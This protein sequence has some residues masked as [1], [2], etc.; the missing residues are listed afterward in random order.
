MHSLFWL[1]HF[2]IEMKW[3]QCRPRLYEL[4]NNSSAPRAGLTHGL[5]GL[6]PWAPDFIGPPLLTLDFFIHGAAGK[7][8]QSYEST[9]TFCINAVSFSSDLC[10]RY[11]T[12]FLHQ[13]TDGT[14]LKMRS[15]QDVLL[16][17]ACQT[18]AGVPNPMQLLE[19]EQYLLIF[20]K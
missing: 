1:I 3:K 12:F 20:K 2:K 7:K 9:C 16:S 15:L 5:K 11:I 14:C 6:Q 18:L 13:H 17:K 4:S 19:N 8:N 10:R